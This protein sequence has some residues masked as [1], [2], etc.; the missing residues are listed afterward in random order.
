MYSTALKRVHYGLRER[1]EGQLGVI[2]RRSNI[3]LIKI[4]LLVLKSTSNLNPC[5]PR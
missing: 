4:N 3:V 1:I 2:V 5:L